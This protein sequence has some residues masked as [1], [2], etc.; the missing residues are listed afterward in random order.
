[1]NAIMLQHHIIQFSLYYLSR[2]RLWEVKNKRKFQTLAL[3]VVVVNCKRWSLKRN[4]R[5]IDFPFSILDNLSLRRSGSSVVQ[6]FNNSI[7]N[8]FTAFLHLN[9]FCF[10]CFRFLMIQVC[11]NNHSSLLTA[12]PENVP[13]V[14]KSARNVVHWCLSLITEL[15]FSTSVNH[16]FHPIREHAH[17]TIHTK[18]IRL[19]APHTP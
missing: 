6:L 11:Q 4:F 7:S 16:I 10:S 2:G 1:M 18:S 12:I 9:K 13:G 14:E 8:P 17:V 15:I 3:K 19:P 5:Y